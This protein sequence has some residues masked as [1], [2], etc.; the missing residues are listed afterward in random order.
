M[1]KEKEGLSNNF[2][3]FPRDF[4]SRGKIRNSKI[5]LYPSY[6]LYI[7]IPAGLVIF[8]VAA[9]FTQASRSR[10]EDA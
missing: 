8:T 4:K 7:K 1:G 10:Q 6:I 5:G 2:R 3:I 9:R